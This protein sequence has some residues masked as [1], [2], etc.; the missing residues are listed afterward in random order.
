MGYNVIYAHPTVQYL[1]LTR[2]THCLNEIYRFHTSDQRK[3]SA[4]ISLYCT[5]LGKLTRYTV[6]ILY[7]YTTATSALPDIN[8]RA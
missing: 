6:R 4:Y 8:A 1:E 2:Y 5:G 7:S 3:A